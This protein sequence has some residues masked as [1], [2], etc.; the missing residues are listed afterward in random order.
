[1]KKARFEFVDK[2]GRVVA[3]G[4]F[5][6]SVIYPEDIPSGVKVRLIYEEIEDVPLLWCQSLLSWKAR[7]HVSYVCCLNRQVGQGS[8]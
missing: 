4:E 1:M 3:G 7:G 6:N 2:G 5:N 8:T